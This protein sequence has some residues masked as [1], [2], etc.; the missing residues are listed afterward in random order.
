MRLASAPGVK[1]LKLNIADLKA[2]DKVYRKDALQME[3]MDDVVS[4]EVCKHAYN[5]VLASE[6]ICLKTEI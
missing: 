4:L 3:I 6:D 2:V 1:D 5:E